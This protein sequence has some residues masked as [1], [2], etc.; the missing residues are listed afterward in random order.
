MS[1]LV[2]RTAIG[3]SALWVTFAAAPALAQQPVYLCSGVYTDKPCKD[4]REVDINPTRGAHSMSGTRRESNDAVMERITRDI[5]KAQEEGV[6]Q[7][8]AIMRC[9]ELRRQ[10]AAIDKSG[11]AEDFKDQR[12]AIREEQFRLRCKN[13]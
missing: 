12:F 5:N 13:T 8:S 11:R 2:L 7:G 4:G 9:E 1:S 10:R 3:C 6:R